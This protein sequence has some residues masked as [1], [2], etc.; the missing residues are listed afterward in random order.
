MPGGKVHGD[1][2]H[3]LQLGA[4][5]GQPLGHQPG[6]Q[7][8]DIVDIIDIIDIRYKKFLEPDDKVTSIVAPCQVLVA[9]E[10]GPSHR[11]R[12]Q[13]EGGLHLAE[14]R[15]PVTSTDLM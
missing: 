14:A 15:Q 9:A 8:A 3:L 13:E 12:G 7:A 4:G 6:H 5:A 10:H 2:D 1:W 11:G